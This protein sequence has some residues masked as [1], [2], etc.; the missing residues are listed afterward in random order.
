MDTSNV[1]PVPRS[2]L[3]DITTGTRVKPSV[4]RTILKALDACEQVMGCCQR[5]P[6][7]YHSGNE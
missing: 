6:K 5:S 1:N 4:A 3:Q 2:T 7:V